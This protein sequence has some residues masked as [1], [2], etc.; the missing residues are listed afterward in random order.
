MAEKQVVPLAVA[1]SEYE[2]EV[3][4]DVARGQ[5]RIMEAR[6][7]FVKQTRR[8][9]CQELLGCEARNE[10]NIAT[11]E[12]KNLFKLYALEDSDCCIRTCCPSIRPWKMNIS[13]S[14]KD[15]T[16]LRYETPMRCSTSGFKCC[17]HQEVMA[18]GTNGQ[19]YGKVKED[20]YFCIPH[21]TV[22]D[23]NNHVKQKIMPPTCC[24]G[25]MVDF[26]EDGKHNCCACRIPC[27]IY[28]ANNNTP[29]GGGFS[30]INDGK[31]AKVW[32]GL[33]TEL[34]SD[35]TN[36]ELEFPK[37]DAANYSGKAR[38][39]GAVFLINQLFFERTNQR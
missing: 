34:F 36:F 1:Y 39:L 35:A 27:Y 2:Q 14:R 28:P 21:F 13:T 10:F 17:C 12:N 16:F 9:L 20:F 38:L 22:Y 19:Y 5:E 3:D 6:N 11:M 24:C 23:E 32:S 8:G 33:G 4:E 15:Q 29:N 25:T 37:E 7:F 30:S 31:I 18:R 26:C